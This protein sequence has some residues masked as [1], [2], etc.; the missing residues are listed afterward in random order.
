MIPY[1]ISRSNTCDL[2]CSWFNLG[3]VPYEFI[4]VK[5][6]DRQKKAETRMRS[7]ERF[8]DQD[9]AVGLFVQECRQAM[10]THGYEHHLADVEAHAGRFT[11]NLA[12]RCRF[13]LGGKLAEL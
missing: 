12:K 6:P 4:G 13:R 10:T 3:V 9:A 11:T 1:G 2:F 7:T 8:R 5:K